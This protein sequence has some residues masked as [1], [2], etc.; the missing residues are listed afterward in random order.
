MS[1]SVSKLV[2]YSGGPLADQVVRYRVEREPASMSPP[3]PGRF[4][5]AEEA[6]A[7]IDHLQVGGADPIG[8]YRLGWVAG[9]HEP[10]WSWHV[11][12]HGGADRYEVWWWT[13]QADLLEEMRLKAGGG[14]A[15][16]PGP[17]DWN[18]VIGAIG[19][20]VVRRLKREG[21]AGEGEG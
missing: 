14:P 4:R 10:W 2:R 7:R 13:S 9:G 1:D 11:E 6:L 16:E 21:L 20:E 17:Y 18:V 3:N 19:G 5:L 12:R 8:T 15:H